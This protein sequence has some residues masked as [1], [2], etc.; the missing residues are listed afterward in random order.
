MVTNLQLDG[1]LIAE[2]AR[3]G[4]H[5]TKEE[6]VTQALTE[7]VQNLRQEGILDLFGSIDFDPSYDYKRQRT[8]S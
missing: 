5:R 2:A 8:K 3:L 4:K 1:R 7:Y 6:A